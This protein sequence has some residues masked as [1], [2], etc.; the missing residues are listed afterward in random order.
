MRLIHHPMTYKYM[1]THTEEQDY[2]I[3]ICP[4]ARTFR[5]LASFENN[6]LKVNRRKKYYWGYQFIEIKILIAFFDIL[7]IFASE[8]FCLL[9]KTIECNTGYR[10]SFWTFH[11]TFFV[12]YLWVPTIDRTVYFLRRWNLD[13]ITISS[14]ASN[15]TLAPWGILT[16]LP[17]STGIGYP[18][19]GEILIDYFI[20]SIFKEILDNNINIYFSCFDIIILSSGTWWTSYIYS[21][22]RP[23]VCIL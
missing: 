9:N 18:F 10:C 19:F 2:I 16:M 13:K 14:D 15:D 21:G 4:Y 7:M 3:S 17:V 8:H 6:T 20:P 23:F 12:N 1:I 5:L 11:W 22:Y